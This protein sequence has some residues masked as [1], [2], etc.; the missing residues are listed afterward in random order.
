MYR[1]KP[2]WILLTLRPIVEESMRSG[3]LP[4]RSRGSRP[5][6]HQA[7]TPDAPSGPPARMPT[8]GPAFQAVPPPGNSAWFGG[9]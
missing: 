2:Q 1:R 3:T 8:G 5:F 4:R 9:A 6:R 7:K